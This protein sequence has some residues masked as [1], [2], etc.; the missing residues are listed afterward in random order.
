MLSL[1]S[2]LRG[3]NR[4]QQE[5]EKGKSGAQLA[6]RQMRLSTCRFSIDSV[7]CAA[8]LDWIAVSGL[9]TSCPCYAP[10]RN[11]W[12]SLRSGLLVWQGCGPALETIFVL[13]DLRNNE[14]PALADFGRGIHHVGILPLRGT[15][16][17]FPIL[18]ISP[19]SRTRPELIHLLDGK[20][21]FWP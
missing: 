18:Q 1:K 15:L 16:H 9:W 19:F 13:G 11:V 3:G 20:F 8:G 17:A 5:M 21:H 6:T 2:V 4:N 12:K 14:G 7:E 10:P